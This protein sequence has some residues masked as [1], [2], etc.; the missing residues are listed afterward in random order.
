MSQTTHREDAD[1]INENYHVPN[2][3][4]V[5]DFDNVEDIS[6]ANDIYVKVVPFVPLMYLICIVL[7]LILFS[8]M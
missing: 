7:L 1:Y 3:I 5:H 2:G 4:T 8:N 6:F